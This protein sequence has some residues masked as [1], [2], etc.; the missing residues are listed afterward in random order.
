MLSRWW[1]K[2][3]HFM[4]AGEVGGRERERERKIK[5]ERDKERKRVLQ[6]GP[7]S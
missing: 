4:A 7:N 6:L 5:R 3:A 2:A 1:S